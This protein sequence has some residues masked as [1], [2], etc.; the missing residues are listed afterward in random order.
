MVGAMTD[1]SEQKQM[2]IQLSS[3]NK[4]LHQH[5]KE[6]ERSNQE[7]EQFAFIA[8]HDLQEPLRMVSSF[9][10]QLKRKY[11]HLL[12]KKALQ[13][14][15]YA[16]DGASRMKQIILDLLDYSKAGKLAKEL[17]PID[18]NQTLEEYK[19]LR[20]I[21]IEEKNVLIT[22]DVLPTVKSY[23][24]PL[25]QTIHCLLD[26]AIKYSKIGIQPKIDIRVTED[27]HEWIIS[28]KDNGIGINENFFD[29]IFV[30]FQRLHNKN[31]YDGTGISL[32][33]AKKNI[34]ACNGR[35]WLESVINEGSTFYFTIRKNEL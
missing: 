30:I 2:E 22:S 31:Q 1:I 18:L 24:A 26:N 7:L 11:G 15:Y 28:I 21:A 17:V 10:D 33:V 20:R 14:I 3:L 6:L 35:I 25:T 16:S 12:D 13:Y 19:I 32:S 9:M 34:E 27:E 29:K 23:K 8:S 5:A 4:V